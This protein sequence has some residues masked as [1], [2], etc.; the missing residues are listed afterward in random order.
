MNNGLFDGA[1]PQLTMWFG[2]MTGLAVMAIA[3]FIVL[4]IK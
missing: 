1:S 2:L 3:G 4:A